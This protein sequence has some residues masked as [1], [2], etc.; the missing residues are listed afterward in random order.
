MSLKC[1][2]VILLLWLNSA[3]AESEFEF[4]L[5]FVGNP[6]SGKS[7][8]L[9]SL[10]Q[11]HLF[12]SGESYGGGLTYQLDKKIRGRVQ[13]IDTPGLA[14]KKLREEAGKAISTALKAGGKYKIV[15]FVRLESG[16]P[17]NEDITTMKLILEAAP[18][19]GKNYAVILPKITNGAAKGLRD[20]NNL[21]KIY[22]GI[23]NERKWYIS[24]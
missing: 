17:V 8:C 22:A 23:F 24:S 12:K 1:V 4:S 2:I 16:R 5:L 11:E 18:E 7:T 21:S 10:A 20:L 3:I 9:N 13:Y 19:I 14:D 15:F 6:G